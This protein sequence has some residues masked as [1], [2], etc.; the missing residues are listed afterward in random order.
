[1]K[2]KEILDEIEKKAKKLSDK[3]VNQIVRGKRETKDRLGE[4]AKKYEKSR[5]SERSR[6]RKRRRSEKR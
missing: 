2:L 4:N 6:R 3:V 5:R 1:M